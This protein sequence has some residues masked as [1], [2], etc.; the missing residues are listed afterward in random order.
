MKCALPRLLLSILHGKPSGELPPSIT[1]TEAERIGAELHDRWS[2]MADGD[3]P[4][5]REDMA[6]GD[7]VQFV[8][9]RATEVVRARPEA[10]TQTRNGRS[11]R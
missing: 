2:T 8:V 7:I 9:R 11:H 10:E 5:E 1:F 4:L 3:V 6:W